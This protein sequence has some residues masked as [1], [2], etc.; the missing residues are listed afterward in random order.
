MTEV[1]TIASGVHRIPVRNLWL[2]ML[3]A[4]RLY[5]RN[6]PQRMVG[7]EENPD[8]LLNVVGEI[9]VT[10]V[11]RRLLRPLGHT[12]RER[13]A[14]LTRVRGRI[15]AL[16]TES[17]MLLAQG[18]V[19]CTFDDLT[20]DTARN[21][22]LLTALHWAGRVVDDAT[23]A[24]RARALAR[25]FAQYGVQ[26][27]SANW[28]ATASVRLG[29]NDRNDAEAVAAATLLLNM[30]LPT[31]DAGGRAGRDPERDAAIVRALF[32]RAVR[33]FYRTVLTPTWR[34]SPGE[35]HRKWPASEPTPGLLAMLPT[36]RTDI[37]LEREGRRIIVETKFADALKPGFHGTRRLDRNH[38]FQLYAYVQSQS[39][40][41]ELGRT[42]EGVLLYPTV[43]HHFDESAVI[44][45]HRLRFVTVDL[46]APGA[47]IRARLLSAVDS[48]APTDAAHATE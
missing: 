9:L 42:A 26:A 23:T 7:V 46:A 19:A 15:D 22:L 47:E 11:E 34:V 14:V 8:D 6:S 17:R 44:Q 2:L 10:A 21:R 16:T 36:M 28:R 39:V 31:E 3:Y 12:Y 41:D 25:T 1:G 43:G 38:V 24:Q 48:W 33:G 29:R 4:S 5:Q 27:D 37:E 30:L 40:H 35:T 45:G 32:E 18:K 20:V 13:H